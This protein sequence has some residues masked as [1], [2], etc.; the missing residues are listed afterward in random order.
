MTAEE[1]QAFKL[2]I[3]QEPEKKERARITALMIK[4]A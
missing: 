3:A 4:T 1:E 2:E